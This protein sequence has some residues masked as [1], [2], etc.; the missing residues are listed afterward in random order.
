MKK[1]LFLLIISLFYFTN[2]AQAQTME[3]TIN[4]I[5]SKTG[6]IPFTN[7]A[8]FF[9]LKPVYPNDVE[10]IFPHVQY[11]TDGIL[12]GSI[13]D[14][15]RIKLSKV[16]GV[17]YNAF[18]EGQGFNIYLSG[19]TDAGLRLYDDGSTTNFFKGIE[20]LS[21]VKFSSGTLPLIRVEYGVTEDEAKKIKKAYEHLAKLCG[22]KLV[23]EDLFK[24]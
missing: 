5:N 16:T 14:L 2:N 1:T 3:Q 19:S 11:T 20:Q 21:R 18:K 7:Q 10:L 22:A 8:K 13:G 6:L 9:S 12:D 15:R 24:N 23:D 17:T 4:W